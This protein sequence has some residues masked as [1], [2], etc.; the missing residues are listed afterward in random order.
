MFIELRLHVAESCLEQLGVER[1]LDRYLA[2]FRNTGRAQVGAVKAKR[3]PP[4][5][6]LIT[7]RNILMVAPG[8]FFLASLLLIWASFA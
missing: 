5:A 7:S 4:Y 3:L 1:D 2:A 6:R 8:V